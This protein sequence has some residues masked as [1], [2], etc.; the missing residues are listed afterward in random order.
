MKYLMILTLFLSSVG[1][2]QSI[3]R[4]SIN[5]TGTSV[6]QSNHIVQQTVGQPYN[7]EVSNHTDFSIRP[8]FIQSST[9]RI[10]ALENNTVIAINIFPNPAV[11]QVTLRAEDLIENVSISVHDAMGKTIHIDKL[12]EMNEYVINCSTWT[13]GTY[14]ITTITEDGRKNNA[15]LIISK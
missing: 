11:Q 15:K 5:T 14:Y 6:H 10:E 12:T 3:K 2:A 8:G 4:Q 13:N 9:M 7:T 1:Y